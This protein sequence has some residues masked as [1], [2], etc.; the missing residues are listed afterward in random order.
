MRNIN[1]RCVRFRDKYSAFLEPLYHP[2][3]NEVLLGGGA[4]CEQELSVHCY[5][6]WVRFRGKYSALLESLYHPVLNEV[7][8]GGAQELNRKVE[9]PVTRIL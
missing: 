3:L 7:L 5:F 6:L 2:V 4:V 1:F 9:V 8:L